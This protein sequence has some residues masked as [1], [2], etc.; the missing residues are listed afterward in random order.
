MNEYK[1]TELPK[2]TKEAIEKFFIVSR[3]KCYKDRTNIFWEKD[4]IVIMASLGEEV[5][6]RNSYSIKFWLNQLEYKRLLTPAI[7]EELFPLIFSN[8]NEKI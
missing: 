5:I 8:G 3:S 1:Y 4:G 7:E 2:I 6:K